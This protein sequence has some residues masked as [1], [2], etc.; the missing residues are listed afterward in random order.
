MEGVSK[1]GYRHDLGAAD[2]NDEVYVD[3]GVHPVLVELGID[4]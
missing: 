1:V 2:E 3:E 4:G